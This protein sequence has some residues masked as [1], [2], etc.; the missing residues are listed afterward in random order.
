VI[1][2]PEARRTSAARGISR[3]YVPVGDP[4]FRLKNG[5]SREPN[6]QPEIKTAENEAAI[7]GHSQP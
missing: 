2:H 5:S 1:S 4:S 6:C 3:K 7:V